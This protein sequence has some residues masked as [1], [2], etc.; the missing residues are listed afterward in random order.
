MPVENY[1]NWTEPVYPVLLLTNRDEL[2]RK[3]AVSKRTWEEWK[4]FEKLLN[5]HCHYRYRPDLEQREN[6][7]KVVRS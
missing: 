7:H 2:K 1:N 6:H 3:A 5:T 4:Q